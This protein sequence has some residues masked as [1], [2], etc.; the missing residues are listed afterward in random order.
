MSDELSCEKKI[1]TKNIEN[2]DFMISVWYQFGISLVSVFS[3]VGM[4]FSGWF[5]FV[6]FRISRAGIAK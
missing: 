3:F 1:K 2:S 4:S 6:G 5:V